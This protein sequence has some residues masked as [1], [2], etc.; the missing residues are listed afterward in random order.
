MPI[1]AVGSIIDHPAIP[2]LYEDDTLK[3]T[4]LP[5]D[6]DHCLLTFIGVGH[7][8][9]GIDQ[10]NEE[11]RKLGPQWGP[12]IFIFDKKRSWGNAIDLDR[13]TAVTAP[14]RKG[15]TVISIGLS[16]G[17]FLA[18]LASSLV[19]AQRCIS[20]APQFSMHPNI[21]PFERRWRRY[22]LHIT[23]WR[24]PSLEGCFSPAC[25][26]YAFFPECPIERAHQ[27]LFPQLPN[28]QHFRISHPDH[29]VARAL[30]ESGMLYPAL[31]ACISGAAPQEMPFTCRERDG[32]W[33]VDLNQVIPDLTG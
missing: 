30:K 15:R 28:L 22:T 16:M 13:V 24:V 27:A 26:Y 12:Q 17:G 21:A 4:H 9:G 31:R 20:F 7:G 32:V 1:P 5:G 18:I 3:I 14:L 2:T 10:Q 6:G 25:Q 11:F 33:H 19:G 8:L 23:E 29:N